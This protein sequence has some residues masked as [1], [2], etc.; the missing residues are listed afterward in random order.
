MKLTLM[1]VTITTVTSEHVLMEST[2]IPVIVIPATM[3]QD[4]TLRLMN[5]ISTDHVKM[6]HPAQ[7]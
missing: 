6:V 4:V 2:S 5:V 3:V 1:T 7:I